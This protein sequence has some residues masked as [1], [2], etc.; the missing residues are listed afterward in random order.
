L[1][2]EV[3]DVSPE[4][5]VYLEE[6]VAAFYSDCFL[7]TCVMLGSA[8]EIE[9]SRLLEVAKTSDTY[10]RYFS[11]IGDGL[12]IRSK[13]SRFQEAIKPVLNFLPKS[14][15]NNLDLN[16][17]TG[18]SL[19]GAARNDSGEPSGANPPSREQ[20]YIYLQFFIPFAK[21]AMLLRRAFNEPVFP[22]P[23]GALPPG[24]EAR[25]TTLDNRPIG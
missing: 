22:R 6:A 8:A 18:Q 15:T 14:A 11:R 16:L 17:N 1:R 9:F 13:I 3:T 21:Q 20:V 10:G 19:I 5:I 24:L 23:V 12:F 7:S 4:S 25:R 2:S